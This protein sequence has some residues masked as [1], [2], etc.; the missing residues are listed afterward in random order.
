[1]KYNSF[2]SKSWIHNHKYS[3]IP[4]TA[5]EHRQSSDSC[6]LK[7]LATETGKT[8]GLK[9]SRTWP[10]SVK[11]LHQWMRTVSYMVSQGEVG[12]TWG[13][14]I[15][16]GNITLSTL[17]AADCSLIKETTPKVLVPRSCPLEL[18]KAVNTPTWSSRLTSVFTFF[19]VQS[20][21]LFCHSSPSLNWNQTV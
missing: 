16:P 2:L 1:M 11:N 20:S 12:S 21:Y 19:F 4:Q 9:T 10:D 5:P 17:Y 7:M 18:K 3:A 14:K 13:V 15:G 8:L 6:L